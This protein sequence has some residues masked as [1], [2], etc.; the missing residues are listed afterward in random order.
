MAVISMTDQT[1]SL[2]DSDDAWNAEPIEAFTAWLLTPDFVTRG[3]QA[4]PLRASS[5]YVY[6]AMGGKFIREVLIEGKRGWSSISRDDVQQFLERGQLKAGIRN[7]YIRLLERLF[8][9]LLSRGIARVNPA[10]GLAVKGLKAKSNDSTVW[11]S[12]DQEEA[13]LTSLS[14]GEDWRAQRNRAIVAMV[15]GGG[16]KVSELVKLK[17]SSIGL[18]QE[19][20]SAWLTIQ[21]VGAGRVHRTRL[22]PLAAKII[23]VWLSTRTSYQAAG[24]LLFPTTPNGEPMHPSTVYRTVAAVLT[25]AGIDPAIIK[26]RGARTLRNTFAIR[27]LSEG[28]APALVGEYLGHRADRSTRRYTALAKAVKKGSR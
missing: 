8:D 10:R 1:P 14:A 5:A 23:Q 15:L 11:L 25:D 17:S 27:E 26:R 7:R 16:V 3:G 19:D 4:Q 9:D 2:F 28:Q 18:R 13:V 21:A 12:P 6:Q 24:L 22:T 20:G